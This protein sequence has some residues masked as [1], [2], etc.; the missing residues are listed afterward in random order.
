MKSKRNMKIALIVV[1]VMSN[2]MIVWGA[3]TES[4]AGL[5]AGVAGLSAVWVWYKILKRKQK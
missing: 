2:N 4:S 3:V 5:I 1:A